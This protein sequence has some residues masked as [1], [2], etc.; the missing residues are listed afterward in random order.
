M[1]NQ[2]YMS[3]TQYW[4]DRLMSSLKLTDKQVTARMKKLYIQAYKNIQHELLI[5]WNDMLAKGEVSNTALM[6]HER[7]K[8]L[9][10]IIQKELYFLG[11]KQIELLQLSLLDVF[12]QGQLALEESM[13]IPPTTMNEKV[14][15]QIVRQSYKGATFSERI[16]SDMSKLKEQIEK[17]VVETAV[18]GKDVRKVSKELAIRMNVGLSDAKRIVVTETARVFNQGTA[19]RAWENGYTHYKFLAHKDEKTC[20][21]CRELDGKIFPITDLSHVPPIHPHSRSTIL[22]VT[23]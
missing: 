18:Q 10:D 7:Y 8:V 11:E 23:D 21:V 17:K 6:T 5:I 9:M 3:N 12:S 14:A 2:Q 4:E 1:S 16:W 13:D 20:P 15:E 19:Q 22:I